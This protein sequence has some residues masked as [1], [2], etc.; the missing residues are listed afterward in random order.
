MSILR[1]ADY[2][3]SWTRVPPHSGLLELQAALVLYV[4][5]E[6]PFE[7]LLGTIMHLCKQRV[8]LL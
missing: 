5:R 8:L 3:L 7:K 1:N 4:L 6:K 2:T